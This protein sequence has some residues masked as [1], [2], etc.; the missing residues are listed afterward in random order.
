VRYP[1]IVNHKRVGAFVADAVYEERRAG[2][3]VRVIADLKSPA[4][5]TNR[6]YRLKK[7]MMD[8]MGFPV[9]EVL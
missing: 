1:L 4:T 7:K 3:W 8:A 5:R 2:V 6:L 9:T